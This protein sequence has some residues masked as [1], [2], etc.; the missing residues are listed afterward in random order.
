[1]EKNRISEE[2]KG[3]SARTMCDKP[4][5]KTPRPYHFECSECGTI[6]DSTIGEVQLK[7]TKVR[8]WETPKYCPHCG[9]KMEVEE[10]EER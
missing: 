3:K 10:D 2:E 7:G 5:W 1:M 4:H 8:D 9:V 6:Y